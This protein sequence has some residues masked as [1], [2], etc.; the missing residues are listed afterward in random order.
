MPNPSRETPSPQLWRLIIVGRKCL[1]SVSVRGALSGLPL[2]GHPARHS[3]A[4]HRTLLDTGRA[5][6]LCAHV[7]AGLRCVH[8]YHTLSSSVS[9]GSADSSGNLI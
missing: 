7:C 6:E 5:G 8:T 3:T 9:H 2:A 1:V 4:H